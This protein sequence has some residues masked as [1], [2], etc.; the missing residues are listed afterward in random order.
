MLNE[1]SHILESA[2]NIQCILLYTLTISFCISFHSVNNFI[3]YL[4]YFVMALI[5]QWKYI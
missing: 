5:G 4:L 2:Q 3:I 1:L